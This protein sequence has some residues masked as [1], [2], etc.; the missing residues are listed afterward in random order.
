MAESALTLGMQL[1]VKCHTNEEV[2]LLKRQMNLWN[3]RGFVFHT[4]SIRGGLQERGLNVFQRSCSISNVS[5][6]TCNFINPR[7]DGR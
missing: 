2:E 7:R 4:K 3:F 6:G 1:I 5:C